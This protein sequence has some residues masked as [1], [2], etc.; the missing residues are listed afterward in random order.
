MAN[1]NGTVGGP[2]VI[3]AQKRG[4]EL[5]QAHIDNPDLTWAQL[6][7]QFDYASAGAAHNAAMRLHRRNQ[8]DV[9]EEFRNRWD[10]ELYVA[11]DEAKTIVRGTYDARSD[12]EDALM[13]GGEVGTIIAA[14]VDA[15]KRDSKLRLEGIDRIVKIGERL[16]KMHGH[17]QPV[18][19]ETSGTQGFNVIIP[20]A[21]LPEGA[22]VPDDQPSS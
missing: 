10:T 6:A 16:S 19:V 5:L 20:S 12:I 11:L 17:D 9:S 2:E 13:E 15:M 8:K 4:T 21:L 3:A 14:A 7:R 22:S 1:N 18:K